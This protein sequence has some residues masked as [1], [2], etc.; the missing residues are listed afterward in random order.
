MLIAALAPFLLPAAVL[1]ADPAAAP[2]EVTGELRVG[3]PV[4][5]TLTGP[6]AREDGDPNPFTEY[7]VVAVF[8]RTARPEGD[9]RSPRRDM[10]QVFGYF[11]ADGEAGESGALG[12]DRW[13]VHWTPAAPGTWAYRVVVLRPGTNEADSPAVA[14]GDG[15]FEV[16]PAPAATDGTSDLRVRGPLVARDGRLWLAGADE[17]FFKLGTDSPE[18]LLGYADFD[19]TDK[20]GGRTPARESEAVR[21]SLH[22]YEPHVKDWKP[23]DPTWGGPKSGEN[24]SGKNRGKGLIGAL[25]YLASE[26]VNSIY[27]LTMNVEGDGRDVW[28]WTGPGQRTRFDCSKLDQWETVFTHCDRLGIALHVVLTETENENLFEERDGGGGRDVPFAD[29]RNL[30]YRELVARFAHHPALVWNL[31]EENGWDDREKAGTGQSGAANTTAQRRAFAAA[32]RELDPYDHPVVVHTLPGRYDEIYEPLLGDPTLDGVSLQMGNM[33]QTHAETLE[34]ITRSRAAGHP[35]YACLDEIGPPG[36]GV[37]PDDAD[38][39]AKNHADVRRYALWG[40][41]TAGGSGVEWYFGYKHP[42]NDLTLEDFRSRADVWRWS[43]IAKEFAEDH[44]LAELDPAD[45]LTDAK[46]DYAMRSP[47]GRRV[48]LYVPAGVRPEPKLTGGPFTVRWYDPAAGG[49]LRTGSAETVRGP[50]TVALGDPPDG[51]R[52]RDWVVLV[53]AVSPQ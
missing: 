43:R 40:N 18:N 44:G 13:R 19:G 20:V 26:G 41:L 12:G 46:D 38:G 22:R 1:A 30:Y 52:S 50:G 34:W 28:P 35:W 24:R 29:T 2:V 48:L 53:E 8:H 16:A 11:A 6:E 7:G 37:L 45:G 27:F 23:G 4:T 39:A 42:H 31:G 47:D 3:F 17:P 49:E 10:G 51:D 5:L 25:N 14:T 36:E 33:R 15:Q 32:I 9:E 21:K